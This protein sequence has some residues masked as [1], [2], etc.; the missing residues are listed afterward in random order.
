MRRLLRWEPAVDRPEVLEL[1]GEDRELRFEA[2]VLQDVGDVAHRRHGS[3]RQPGPAYPDAERLPPNPSLANEGLGP[4]HVRRGPDVLLRRE[5]VRTEPFVARE[6]RRDDLARRSLPGGAAQE[7]DDAV[8]GDRIVDRAPHG[9]VIDRRPAKVES[10]EVG[11][12]LRR[13]HDLARVSQI[14]RIELVGR[15]R[16]ADPGSTPTFHVT[17]STKPSGWAAPDH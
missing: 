7:L 12:R 10:H 16:I 14:E 5:R 9:D 4:L 3:G 6:V 17:R 1:R 15:W 11:T 2:Q 13:L 8:A